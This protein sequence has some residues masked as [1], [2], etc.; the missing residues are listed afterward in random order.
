MRAETVILSVAPYNTQRTRQALI[1][2]PKKP[3][4]K[5]FNYQKIGI[6]ADDIND[7]ILEGLNFADK[8]NLVPDY[9]QKKS[10]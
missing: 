3:W 1:D 5:L 8:T 4:E 10:G 9:Y 6:M 7:P 2:A